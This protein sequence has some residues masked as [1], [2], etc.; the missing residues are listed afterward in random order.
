MISVPGDDGEAGNVAAHLGADAA[1]ELLGGLHPLLLL[2]L[3]Q[4]YHMIAGAY[5]VFRGQRMSCP[6]PEF[7]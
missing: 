6:S 2:F 3:L 7:F 5:S 4:G 1:N